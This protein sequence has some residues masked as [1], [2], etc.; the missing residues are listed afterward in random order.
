MRIEIISYVS[1]LSNKIRIYLT[2]TIINESNAD[3]LLFSGHTI[4]FVND[5][6]QLQYSINNKHTEVILE[7]KDINSDKIG[8][9]LYRIKN[10]IIKSLYTNQLFSRSSE[11]NNNY[12]LADRL[13]HEFE[14]NRI[15][16]LHGVSFLIIQ[17]GEI[18]ILKNIQSKDNEVEFRFSE[19][20]ILSDTFYKILNKVD[21]VLNPCHTPMGNQGKMEKRRQFLSKKN[22]YYFSTCNTKDNSQNLNIK[23]LQYAFFNGEGLKEVR[24][25]VDQQYIS[26]IY[27]I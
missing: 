22:K 14:T 27:D 1:D 4:D 18:N 6:E 17:C 5:I 23:S 16:K 26:R 15:I 13:L 3:L 12:E 11:I 10:G 24:K 8:N 19:N 20:S 2:S 7:L 21:V 25:D 9:C